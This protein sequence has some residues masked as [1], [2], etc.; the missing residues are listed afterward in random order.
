[1]I[2]TVIGNYPKI[3]NLP[4]P[5]KLR[6]ALSLF[7]KKEISLDE[8]KKVEDEVTVDVMEEQILAGVD[9]ITD[10][11][12]RWED[13]QTYLA[14]GI[15]G[16]SINGLIRYFD[17]NTYYRQPVVVG[18]LKWKGPIL[19]RDYLFAK[20]RSKVPVKAVLTG[21]Y[22]LALLSRDE[23]YK[24][25]ETLVMDLAGILAKEA[26]ALE[27]E[28]ASWIQFDEPA[29]LKHKE[30]FPLF[31]EAMGEVRRDLR[32]MSSLVF[33]FGDIEGL[34]PEILQLPVDIIGLDFV[35]GEKNFEILKRSPFTKSLGFGI[36]DARNTKR[37]TIEEIVE[38][39]GEIR[40][41]VPLE[42]VQVSPNCG[43][44]FLPREVAY[45]KLVLMVK[46]TKKAEDVY[47]T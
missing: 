12:I 29:L 37:E 32:G 44:E 15:E 43:L 22:T 27:D 16:F 38:K 26:K 2:T 17:T 42:N 36:I 7:D 6:N 3:P 13:G 35:M 5:A 33:Y 25:K 18:R 34:Y 30:D 23:Y 41:I 11:M 47:G 31:R 19:L 45:E 21:P 14:R 46:G 4:R 9:L 40:K 10:G 39:I 1:M 8:L 24:D 20:E 28:G